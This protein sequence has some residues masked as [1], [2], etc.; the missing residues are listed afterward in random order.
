MPCP[1]S[2]NCSLQIFKGL[3][4]STAILSSFQVYPLSTL[5]MGWFLPQITIK[6][7]KIPFK[8][9]ANPIQIPVNHHQITINPDEIP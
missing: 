8:S 3:R 4:A 9:H 5:K 2:G 7:N 1:R 6:S